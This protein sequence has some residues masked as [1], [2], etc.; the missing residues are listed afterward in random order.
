MMWATCK[1]VI[2]M[3]NAILRATGSIQFLYWIFIQPN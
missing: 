3:T 2:F 1:Q